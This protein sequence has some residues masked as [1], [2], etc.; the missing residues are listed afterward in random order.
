MVVKG[1]HVYKTNPLLRPFYPGMNSNNNLTWHKATIQRDHRQ[2]QNAHRSY[3]LWFTGLSGSGKST[4]AHA[5]ES[6][7]YQL[8]CHTYVLDGDN[9]R[10]GLCRDL[11]FS[12]HDRTENIR[13]IGEV[14]KLLIDAGVIALTA[15]ISPFQADR[16]RVRQMLAR[17]EFIEIYCHCSLE[18]CESR[19]VKGLY[20][21]AR[22]G[23]I[24]NFTGISSPY[25]PPDNPELIIDTARKSEDECVQSVMN[26]LGEH[27]LLT[28]QGMKTPGN[29]ANEQIHTKNG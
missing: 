3:V 9:V 13:R 23:L 14:S 25:E 27:H 22:A 11:G 29:F 5:V 7:L 10:H 16:G 26:Y 4:L 28:W 20:Q 15:F 21:R 6:Q 12:E 18:V 24:E 19:D 17:G 1:F 2:S 8:G